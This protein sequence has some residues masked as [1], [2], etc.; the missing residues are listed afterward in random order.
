MSSSC[1]EG[2]RIGFSN[3]LQADGVLGHLESGLNTP[4]VAATGKDMDKV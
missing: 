3:A 4:V 1:G 2:L